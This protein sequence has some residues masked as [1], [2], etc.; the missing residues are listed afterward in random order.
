MGGRIGGGVATVLGTLWL[1]G[2]A[3]AGPPGTRD[4]IQRDLDAMT[5][6]DLRARDDAGLKR[7]HRALSKPSAARVGGTR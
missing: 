3:L 7:L 4:Q 6:H 2:A 1:T 5:R